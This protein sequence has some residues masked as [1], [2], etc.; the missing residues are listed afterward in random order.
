MQGAAT[1]GL[2]GMVFMLGV[3]YLS[4][5]VL[6]A[7]LCRAAR[8]PRP[9]VQFFLPD[10]MVF[11]A[12][13]AL[14]G[15]FAYQTKSPNGWDPEPEFNLPLMVGL[16]A[17]TLWAW[18]IALRWLSWAEVKDTHL[19][20]LVLALATPL[21]FVFV[22]MAALAPLTVRRQMY[23]VYS[24]SYGIPSEDFDFFSVYGWHL[25][26]PKAMSAHAGYYFAAILLTTLILASL[27]CRKIARSAVQSA[28]V[29]PASAL[30]EPDAQGS[31]A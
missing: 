9:K 10:L 28:G 30:E 27:L 22:P 11:V 21:A 4:A 3:A 25:N 29:P 12:Q 17:F 5:R 24:V 23:T 8:H 20:A 26:I 1:F 18:W 15:W 16:V 7:P 14:C 31:A 19:R 13:A 6:L 2:L